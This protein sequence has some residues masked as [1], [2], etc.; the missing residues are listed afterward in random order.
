MFISFLKL[1]TSTGFTTSSFQICIL[2]NHLLLYVKISEI[3]RNV[4][5]ANFAKMSYIFSAILQL[6]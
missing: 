3:V 5:N 2:S 6:S 4:L 1:S